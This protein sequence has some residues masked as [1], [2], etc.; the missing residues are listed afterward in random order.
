MKIKV[1]FISVSLMFI[2]ACADQGYE[3][4]DTAAILNGEEITYE[5]ILWQYSLTANIEDTVIGYLKQEIVILEAQDMGIVVSDEEVEEN[6]RLLFPG[7]GVSERYQ[8]LEDKQFYEEQASLLGVSPE[9]YYE[10]WEEKAYRSQ[11]YMNKYI[12]KNFGTPAEGDDGEA[13][14]QQINDH[15]DQ[16][17]HDYIESGELI[18]N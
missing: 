1:L 16:L 9:D 12:E 11:A 13:W 8:K 14:G 5:D 15:I 6:K 2:A 17:F 10:V 4:E 3:K 7:S 18:I